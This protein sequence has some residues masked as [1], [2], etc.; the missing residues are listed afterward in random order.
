MLVTTIFSF[1]H[2]VFKTII[3]YRAIVSS[4]CVRA[5]VSSDFVAKG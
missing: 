3:L 4:D 5:I 2:N 1:S